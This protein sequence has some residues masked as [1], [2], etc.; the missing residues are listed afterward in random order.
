MPEI[1]KTQRSEIVIIKDC[2]NVL[3]TPDT[4]IGSTKMME[5]HTNQ[6]KNTCAK[7]S[8]LRTN[9]DGDQMQTMTLDH[10]ALRTLP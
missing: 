2:L 1:T 10:G 6:V 5:K 3:Q 7:R 9:A 8:V 4:S